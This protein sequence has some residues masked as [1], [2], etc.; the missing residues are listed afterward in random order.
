MALT[1]SEAIARREVLGDLREH[2][3]TTLSPEDLAELM[4]PAE[5]GAWG[6]LH[7]AWKAREASEKPPLH[8]EASCSVI[9]GNQPERSKQ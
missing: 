8:K 5:W 9:R 6:A 2:L 1:L 3:L 7:D 4:T